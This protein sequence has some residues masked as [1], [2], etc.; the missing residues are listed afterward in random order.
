LELLSDGGDGTTTLS[1]GGIS[2]VS[3]GTHQRIGMIVYLL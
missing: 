2:V 3:S 1:A